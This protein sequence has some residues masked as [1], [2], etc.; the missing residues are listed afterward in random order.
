MAK[1]MIV[2][3]AAAAGLMSRL[4]VGMKWTAAELQQI[5]QQ[6][7]QQQQQGEDWLLYMR[8]LGL[9]MLG[10]WTF[11]TS[12]LDRLT[13]MLHGKVSV[14]TCAALALPV[15]RL[16]WAL[17]E[18]L[19]L[20]T[21][22]SSSSSKR[23]RQGLPAGLL[24]AATAP[25]PHLV[26]RLLARAAHFGPFT[27][28]AVANLSAGA[29]SAEACRNDELVQQL[30]L[31]IAATAANFRRLQDH[32]APAARGAGSSSRGSTSNRGRSCA[33]SSRGISDSDV[34]AHHMALLAALAPVLQQ[35]LSFPE[36]TSAIFA[37]LASD[38]PT[39]LEG[40]YH[41]LV[42]RAQQQRPRS[43]ASSSG[44]GM[45]PRARDWMQHPELLPISNDG[46]PA[47]AAAAAGGVSQ[48]AAA[49]ADGLAAPVLLQLAPAV[50][51]LLRDGAGDGQA[52]RAAT[53]E[54]NRVAWNYVVLVWVVLRHGSPDLVLGVFR[55]N[56]PAVEAALEA[57]VRLADG[58]TA[59]WTMLAV[60]LPD[61]L[62]FM[63]HVTQSALA[64]RCRKSE[65]EVGSSSSSRSAAAAAAAAD[66]QQQQQQQQQ[67]ED[68]EALANIPVAITSMMTC[69][70]GIG[71][72][73]PLVAGASS[74]SSSSSSSTPQHILDVVQF[75]QRL[76]R[77]L[78]AAGV[79]ETAEAMQ[80]GSLRVAGV[81]GLTA[82]LK[83][84][85]PAAVVSE[86]LQLATAVC[87]QLALLGPLC[88][89]NPGCTNCTKLSE[90]ELV[91]GKG[92]VCSGCRAVRLCSAECNKAYWKA[93]HKQAC[94]ALKEAAGQQQQ[95]QQQ[96]QR[97]SSSR[98]ASSS[99]RAGAGSRSK[100]S[101]KF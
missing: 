19:T 55:R 70:A 6:Q 27:L 72:L 56:Q 68:A 45:L 74:S 37:D 92:T 93:G 34:P 25:T 5:K 66:P 59:R 87:T 41:L 78:R 100:F 82:S 63:R 101:F 90:Q 81:G 99:S 22:G 51:Q 28:R 84:L 35:P 1:Q 61:V 46:H 17:F 65:L 36:D 16:E 33:G 38:A 10:V 79:V 31:Y 98:D 32:T 14:P 58:S 15:A 91:A 23:S 40:T 9:T 96:Q 8:G 3:S 2:E 42:Q 62:N 94:S 29:F 50:M 89:A 48:A 71:I 80:R 97:G 67:L 54:N 18:T 26:E 86:M 7:Q 77:Q 60:L 83:Q 21:A 53:D 49:V 11:C 57:A 20:T 4:E 76:Q 85:L 30:L 24:P 73:L 12:I 64:S 13:A 43:A 69:V 44:G 47:A 52:G 88:C 95:Q 75:Q 39:I